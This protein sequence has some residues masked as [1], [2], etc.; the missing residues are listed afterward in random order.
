MLNSRYARTGRTSHW[1][2]GHHAG[3][4]TSRGAGSAGPA[5]VGEGSPPARAR[6]NAPR[7]ADLCRRA[8]G[9]ITTL[10]L[11]LSLSGTGYGQTAAST[12]AWQA[13]NRQVFEAYRAGHYRDAE[14]PARQALTLATQQFGPRHPDTLTSKNNLAFVL[15]RQG[16]YAEAEPLYHETLQLRR[17]VLG[18]RHP[19]T[20]TSMNN[21][22]A[23]LNRQR[24][25]AEAE[26][27]FR[28]TLQLLR[29]VLGSLH[30]Y[31][32]TTQLNLT[33]NLAAQG[34]SAQA[35]ALHRQM[36]PHVI[37][38][39]GIELYG[40]GGDAARRGLVGS[41]ASYQD[42][43]FTLAAAPNAGPE[44]ADLAASTMVRFK[45]LAVE[46]DAY[47]ARMGRRGQDP[48]I[49][50]VVRDIA[51]LRQH[52]ARLSQGGGAD[53]IAQATAQLDRQELALGRL[54][55]DYRPPSLQVRAVSVQDLRATLG[56]LPVASGMLELRLFQPADFASGT[57][58]AP[59]W[60]GVLVGPGGDIVARDLGPADA[61]AAL[62]AAML[63]EPVAA[64][65]AARTLYAQIVGPFAAH[66]GGVRRLYVAPDGPL[67]LLSFGLL[68]DP[69]GQLLAQTLD[70]RTL[71]SGRDLLRPPTD[72]PAKGLVAVGGIDFDAS[73]TLRPAPAESVTS[74]TSLTQLRA[75]AAETL[76]DGFRTL[77]AS[78]T[79][80]AE[81]ARL[82]RQ[83]RRDEPVRIANAAEPSK[84]WLLALPPPRVLHLATHG[85]Y[86]PNQT[87]ER[88]MLL[89]GVALAGAN[90]DVQ[91]EAQDGVLYALEAQD[92]NLE[93]TELVVLSACDTAKGTIDYSDGV[94]GL[95]RALRVAGARHVLVS[96][97]PVSD[98]GAAAF[99]QRF[100]H[101]W[102]GQERSDPAAALRAAQQEAAADGGDRTWA[103]FVLVG[104]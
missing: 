13:L 75:S 99:M 2:P 89:A 47:L 77:P 51:A 22:A 34:K 30:P 61:T 79:E 36:E 20:L 74:P 28:E 70:V 14:A 55:H 29:E 52:L 92:L 6:P 90:R 9:L 19:D 18:P 16:R 24:R 65:T 43:A 39:L 97:R 27:L 3:R 81:I 31:T 11:V 83:A 101:Y 78:A 102:L 56:G 5:A 71:Q 104:G 12:P 21:L 67:H 4:S 49:R 96:L 53:A 86:R 62:V 72:K 37:D 10:V 64:E 66:L 44:A 33:T 41:Q 63:A 69:A 7:F 1:C 45:G 103:S 73:P 50:A 84:S 25:Y 59:H 82:Y 58:G 42:V 38:W 60:L 35:V 87:A 46:E 26:P 15:N 17:E 93:G 91:G 54:S 68:R 80:V 76:R 48:R 98:G 95:V 100:Y 23:V 88:S 85:F 57:M 32:R 8:G 94:S 40:T